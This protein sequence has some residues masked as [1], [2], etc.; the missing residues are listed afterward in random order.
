MY[1]EEI[2]KIMSYMGQGKIS[3][4]HDVEIGKISTP[5]DSED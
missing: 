2:F 1:V 4:L 3:I 5:A